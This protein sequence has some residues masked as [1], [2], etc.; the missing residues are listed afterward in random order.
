MTEVNTS[1]TKRK[2][3]TQLSECEICGASA[4]YS[5][6]GAKACHACKTFFRRNAQDDKVRICILMF[7]IN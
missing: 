5:F 7:L 1:S 2:R 6:Y 3:T 4:I